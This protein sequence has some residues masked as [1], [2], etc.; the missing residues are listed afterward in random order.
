M[1]IFIAALGIPNFG[2]CFCPGARPRRGLYACPAAGLPPAQLTRLG[3]SWAAGPWALGWE[4][5]S[6]PTLPH[7]IPGRPA[8]DRAAPKAP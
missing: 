7:T 4:P 6:S 3:L 8:D 2:V 1:C 5:P